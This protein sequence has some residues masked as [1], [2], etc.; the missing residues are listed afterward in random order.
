MVMDKMT[1]DLPH[2]LGAAEARRRVEN[3]TGQLVKRLP[4]GATVAPR[5]EGNR[6]NLD[7]VALGQRVAAA[8]DVQEQIVRIEVGLPAALSFL[9]PLIEAGMRR[10]GS[11]LLENKGPR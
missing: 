2:S 8:V 11:E 7:I 1:V 6:L 3:S 4:P 10:A 9:R 5:W